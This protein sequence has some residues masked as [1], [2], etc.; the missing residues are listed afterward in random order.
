MKKVQPK[1]ALFDAMEFSALLWRRK[2]AGYLNLPANQPLIIDGLEIACAK[3]A[4]LAKLRR[5]Q[6]RTKAGIRS[7]SG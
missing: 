6:S 7:V 2:R 4:L 5:N 3:N 1:S